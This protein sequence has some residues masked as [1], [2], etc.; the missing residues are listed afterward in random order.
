MKKT[1]ALKI[2]DYFKRPKWKLIREKRYKEYVE[3]KSK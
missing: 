1:A 2:R 3:Y